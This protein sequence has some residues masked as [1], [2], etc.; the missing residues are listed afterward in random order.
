MKAKK[1]LPEEDRSLTRLILDSIAD[2]V[3]TVDQG[4][5]ITS[6]NKAAEQIT[7]ISGEEA[8]GQYCHE[9]FRA[10]ICFDAC[11]LKHT[12]K[13]S[14]SITDFE[15]NILNRQNQE[16]PISISTA[17]LKDSQGKVIGVVETFRDISLIAQ[18]RK[19]ISRGYTFQDIVSKSKVIA[20]LLHIL[21]DVAESE[22]TVIIQGES[23]TGKELF[24]TAIH[25]LSLR[26][27]GPLIKV[28]CGALP[29][30]LLESELFGYKEGAF[31]DAKK[32]K[33]GRFEQAE[34]GTLFFDEI[35][36]LTKGTQVKLLRVLEQKEYEPLGSNLTKKADV[37]ILAAT[38]RDLP[39]LVNQ[40][41]F[42]EDLFYRLNVMKLEIPPLRDRREDVTV[43]ID[44]FIEKLNTKTGKQI[45]S[46]SKA[47]MRFML[48]H[49]YPGNVRELENII[50][51][52][53]ILCKGAEI[54]ITHL[55]RYLL[56]ATEKGASRE[57]IGI[58]RLAD[59]EKKVILETLERHKGDRGRAAEELK[60]HRSTLWR[61]MKKYGVRAA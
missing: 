43:L 33:P 8:I 38:H 39:S 53:F 29:E 16:I 52:A 49:N 34:G 9:I 15:V 31:T 21:P 6:F 1:Q 17:I 11:P 32:D 56:P 46:F 47:A 2:G 57:P 18:L 4:G 42:R 13:T 27:K 19:E 30:T 10:N 7:G 12:A 41:D 59:L 61:K 20:E 58:Q 3:F 14:E 51:H 54:K 44:H 60:V 25:N 48:E 26:K 28:N 55:P 40:G 35:G 23:G 45:R 50:E 22:A 37:R 5:R 24:A 36:D